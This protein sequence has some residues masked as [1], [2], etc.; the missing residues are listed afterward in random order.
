VIRLLARALAILLLAGIALYR[1]VLSPL[2]GGACRFHPSCSAYG[3][4]ALRRHGG[5]RGARLTAARILR[6][7]PGLPPGEDPVP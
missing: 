4:E 1:A 3:V 2:L 5:W 6:C 7:R